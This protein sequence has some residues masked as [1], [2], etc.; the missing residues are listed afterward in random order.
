MAPYPK[1]EILILI[2]YWEKFIDIYIMAV[3]GLVCHTDGG[4]RYR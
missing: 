1:P 3:D 2:F 4:L